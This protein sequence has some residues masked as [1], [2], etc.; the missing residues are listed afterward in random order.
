M[1]IDWKIKGRQFGNCNCN[2][3]CPCQF[4]APPT[5]N[6]CHG[7]GAFLIDEGFFDKVDLAGVKAVS[8]MKFPGPIH[9]GDGEMQII[10]DSNSSSDQRNAIQSIIY[11]EE[12]EPMATAFSM[13]V[14]MMKKIYD[15]LIKSIE[16]DINIETRICN[17]KAEDI[18]TT[19]TEP[20]KNPIT[21]EEHR[22]RINLPNGME[23]KEAEMGSGTTV[24]NAAF[25][26]N[27]KGT[28]VQIARL[29]LTPK[30]IP[31]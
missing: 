25:E 31:N 30:G 3:G 11:G 4:N 18:I 26:T 23:F 5:D 13:Y 2:Y 14:S 29:N 1:G 28:Y 9:E 21:G 12:T 20:I 27:F 6:Y 17:L 15:P 7:M 19:K 16:L 10:L 8:M 22:A 24:A